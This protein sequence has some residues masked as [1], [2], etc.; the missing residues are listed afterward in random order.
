[1]FILDNFFNWPIITWVYSIFIAILL[2]SFLIVIFILKRK[3]TE[4]KVSYKKHSINHNFLKVDLLNKEV[5]IFNPNNNKISKELSL[6]KFLELISEEDRNNFLL[7]CEELISNDFKENSEFNCNIFNTKM[8]L[9]NKK[10]YHKNLL[11]AY[12]VIKKDKIIYFDSKFL[13]NLPSVY[14]RNKNTFN[15]ILYDFKDISNMYE[16]GKFLRGCSIIIKIE[17]KDSNYISYNENKIKYI[18][19]D[20]LYEILPSNSVYFYFK[21]HNNFEID[22]FES[23]AITRYSL[24]KMINK[25]NKGLLK[26]F[27]MRNYISNFNFYIVAGLVS[28]LNHEYDVMYN[29]LED[30]YTRLTNEETNAAIFKSNENQIIENQKD[31]L[32]N[33]IRDKSI[34]YEFTNIVKITN[35]NLRPISNFGYL[36]DFK[37][38][39]DK[40]DDFEDLVENSELFKKDK[41]IYTLGIREILPIYLS[42]RESYFSKLAI[43]IK[44]NNLMNLLNSLTKIENINDTHLMF[45]VDLRELLNN[46]EESLQLIE[47]LTNVGAEIGG[48]IENNDIYI[49]KNI[50]SKLNC[51]FVKTNLNKD[52]KNDSKEFMQIHSLLDRIVGFNKPLIILGSNSFIEIELF[53]K[54]GINYFGSEIISQK[55]NSINPIERKIIKKLSNIS[56]N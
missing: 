34:K 39:D 31:D 3:D 44:K 55:S 29:Q 7:W 12:N 20:S 33:I 16:N 11:D 40:Y 50:C 49:N 5:T 45:I 25:I 30:I 32:I 19:L 41:D 52:V 54:S 46:E 36:V 26:T 9:E 10:I 28:E 1:M 6:D 53:N 37:F 38:N 51:F 4:I 24:K 48:L 47:K 27:E 56:K 8:I 23:K 21:D 2:I 13:L 35:S 22:L 18:L 42:Q 43:K 14:N 17:K 15:P